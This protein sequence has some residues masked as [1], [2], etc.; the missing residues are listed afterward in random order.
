MNPNL[1]HLSLKLFIKNKI[2]IILYIF[3]L[4]FGNYS[5]QISDDFRIQTLEENSQLL[6]VNDYHNFSLIVTTS[7]NIYTGIPPTLRTT[8]KA[9]L[10]NSSSLITLNENYLLASCLEDSL[11]TKININ[12]GNYSSLLTYSDINDENLNLEIPIKSC[13]L[14]MIDNIIFIGYSRIDY[15]ETE[16]NKTN[17]IIKFNITNLDSE[18]GPELEQPFEKKIFVFPNSTILTNSSRQISCLPLKRKNSNDIRLIC[19]HENLEFADKSYQRYRYYVWA[20]TINEELNGFEKD[21]EENR[22]YRVDEN[23]GFKIYKLNDYKARCVMKKQIKDASLKQ[24]GNKILIDGSET[25]STIKEPSAD[26]DLFDYNNGLVFYAEKINYTDI[27]QIYY[28]RINNET[29]KIY[30]KLFNYK[31]NNI[32]K[33]LGYYNK[34][35]EYVILLYQSLDYIKYFVFCNNQN[36]YNLN[37][38]YKIFEPKSDEELEYDASELINNTIYSTNLNLNIAEVKISNN[39]KTITLYFGNNYYDLYMK[40]NKIIIGKYHKNWYNYSLSLFDHVS[41]EYTR[42]YYLNNIKII[43]KTCYTFKCEACRQDYNTCEIIEK[44]KPKE[45][46]EDPDSCYGIFNNKCYPRCPEGTCLD[47]DDIELLNCIPVEANVTVLNYICF[48]DL[49]SIKQNIK[50]ISEIKDPISNRPDIII[51]GYSTKSISEE[52]EPDANY[53]IVY[54]NECENLLKQ[55]YDLSNDAELYILGIDSPNKNKT[56]STSVYNYGVLLENGTELDHSSA[57]KNV[58]ITISSVISDTDSVKLEQAKYFSELGYDIYDENSRFYTDNCAP[59]SIDGND[60]TLVDRKKDYYPSNISLCNES[61]Y[62]ISI[63]YTSKRILCQCDL[64]YNFSSSDNNNKNEENKDDISYLDYFLSLINY[65]ISICYEL[66]FDFN[67]YYYNAGFYI[68]TGTFAFCLC[69]MIIF[70]KWGIKDINKIILENIPNLYKLEKLYEEQEEKRKEL[71]KL[72][73]EEVSLDENSINVPPK[74]RTKKKKVDEKNDNIERINIEEKVNNEIIDNNFNKNIINNINNNNHI[75]GNNMNS[76]LNNNIINI[77]FINNNIHDPITENKEKK[78]GKKKFRKKKK[79]R[80]KM[81]EKLDSYDNNNLINQIQLKGKIFRKESSQ[82]FNNISKIN[83]YKDKLSEYRID[84]KKNEINKDFFN[85]ANY[86]LD[87]QV[88]KKELNNIPYTQALRIDKRNYIEIFLSVIANEIDII[89]I[90]YYKN[91]FNQL[92]IVISTYVFELCLDLTLNC[93]LYTDDVVSEKYHNDGSIGFFTSLTLS[94]MSNIFSSIIAYFIS[95]L[96]DYSEILEFILKDSAQKEE[97][98][99]NIIK[100]RKFLSLKL[101]GYYIAQIA[102]NFA[103]CY[104]LMIFC[105]VYHKTQGSIMLNYLIGITESLAISI[106]LSIITSLIRFLSIKYKW[107]SLYYTS[108]FFFEK[109]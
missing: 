48:K 54:L 71:L 46:Y 78:F 86:T 9:S 14:S 89:S 17:I 53:S 35:S 75:L 51:K 36:I 52:V 56:F 68:A 44:E 25:K 55:Y 49:E 76:I 93:F 70:I 22:I 82:Y 26:L 2:I 107:R 84:S 109:F 45:Y 103:M 8:T 62:Y 6:E 43:V 77:N 95:K 91:P 1:K 19:M 61:C 73:K 41:N 11:L 64:S 88:N 31:E 96:V 47:P 87:S 74:K 7:K 101:S 16:T 69:E 100:F 27:N 65:K 13:S 90:F 33:L 60:I 40:N 99:L 24:D 4:N 67:S 81:S 83:F 104:Y 29:S 79:K 37:S 106:G 97:Y 80:K 58:T 10:I 23:S 21:F 105:T 72:E 38:S 85:I 42:M 94:F 63:N 15:F 66:F 34:T 50:F 12:N 39:T 28:F 18:N 32:Q 5:N 59:A 57:C 3:S 98:F 102:F 20:T 92:S 30:F 108:K